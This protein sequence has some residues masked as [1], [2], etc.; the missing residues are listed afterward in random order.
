MAA[1]IDDTTDTAAIRIHAKFHIKFHLF[2]FASQNFIVVVSGCGGG[3]V[4]S[5]I[6]EICFLV[7]RSGEG[8]CLLSSSMSRRLVYLEE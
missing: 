2:F 5:S 7:Y 8:Q 4:N 6:R 3:G 1:F